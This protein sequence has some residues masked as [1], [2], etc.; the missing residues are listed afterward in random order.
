MARDF[1][2]VKMPTSLFIPDKYMDYR[3]WSDVP[4]RIRGRAAVIHFDQYEQ[5]PWTVADGG[6]LEAVRRLAI[7]GSFDVVA[8]AGQAARFAFAVAE[9]GLAKGL[10]FF[11]PSLDRVLDEV[12]SGLNGLDLDEEMDPYRPVISALHEPDPGRRRDILLRVVR[13]TAGPDLEPAQL[14][15]AIAMASDHAEELFADLRVTETAVTAG[16]RQQ[17]P[18]WLEQPWIDHVA[19]LAI[20]ITVVVGPRGLAIGEAVARRAV[21]VEVVVAE[22]SPGL[23]PVA[24]RIRSADALVRM[25]DRVT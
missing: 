19:E 23:A 25:L 21:D 8:A 22:G 20:P 10:V 16:L 14:E 17:D 11:Y 5:V 1:E 2:K 15:L 12:V 13:E 4:E 6:F 9:A 7:D 3:M 24:E 18:P